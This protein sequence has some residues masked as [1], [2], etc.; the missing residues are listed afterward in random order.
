MKKSPVPPPPNRVNVNSPEFEALLV[1]LK[2]AGNAA[3]VETLPSGGHAIRVV[4][5][6]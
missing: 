4:K 3:V 5:D 1:S 2:K 6:P